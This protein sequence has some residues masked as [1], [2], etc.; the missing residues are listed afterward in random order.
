M[1]RAVLHRRPLTPVRA[2]DA[3]A[4]R[5]ALVVAAALI[6]AGG[7]RPFPGSDPGITDGVQAVNQTQETIRFEVV[8]DGGK[9]FSLTAEF[10]PGEGGLVL[11]G[12]AIGPDS[13]V[14]EDGCTTGDLIALD[15]AG[16]EIARHPPP[17][18][19]GDVFLVRAAPDSETP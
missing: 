15:T 3:R 18:C 1:G 10:E 12:S 8:G 13:L 16:T 7:C 14:T 17:L 19:D 6:L 5:L 11:G 4:R 9:R 2:F